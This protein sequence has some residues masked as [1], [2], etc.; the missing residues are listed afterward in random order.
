MAMSGS[1]ARVLACAILI[2][3]TQGAICGNYGS[4]TCNQSNDGGCKCIW[5]QAVQTCSKT[6]DCSGFGITSVSDSCERGKRNVNG[7]C[8]PCQPGTYGDEAGLTECKTCSKGTYANSTGS[9]ACKVCSRG[10]FQNLTGASICRSCP[11]GK[12]T[13]G[14]KAIEL[15]ECSS[16]S[17]SQPVSSLANRVASAVFC[18][19]AVM[20]SLCS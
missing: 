15:D 7:I 11:A 6:T 17:P 18:F 12:T 19:A 9:T 14:E 5:D 2:Q 20:V 13:D 16:E 3:C 8:E 1:A 10:S 4:D